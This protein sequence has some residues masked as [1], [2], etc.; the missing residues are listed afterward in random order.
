[1]RFA[2]IIGSGKG[3]FVEFK[4]EPDMPTAGFDLGLGHVSIFS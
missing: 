1:M 4:P 2:I 3:E